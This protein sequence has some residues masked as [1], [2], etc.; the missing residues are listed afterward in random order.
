MMRL[1]SCFLLLGFAGELT[2]LGQ[3]SEGPPPKQT[4]ARLDQF[5]DPLP[6]GVLARMGSMR[7]DCEAPILA[8]AFAADGKSLSVLTEGKKIQLRFID[9]ATWKTT[10]R[11]TVP[12]GTIEY[13]LTPDNRL[14]VVRI[15]H[16]DEYCQEIRVLDANT[17]KLVWKPKDER[18]FGPMALSPDGKLLAGGSTKAVVVWD[19]ATGKER[20]VVTCLLNPV[21]ELVF[22]ADGKRLLASGKVGREL[23]VR[24]WE[25]PSG[26]LLHQVAPGG[27][28]YALSPGGNAL[29]FWWGEKLRLWDLDGGR[30]IAA[31]PVQ[32]VMSWNYRF[33][34]DGRGLVTGSTRDQLRVWDTATGQELR[35]LKGSRGDAVPLAFSPEGRLLLTCGQGTSGN[36]FRIW[37]V[38]RGRELDRF[39]G[40]HL[41]ISCLAFSPD[42]KRL[43]SGSDDHTARIWETTSGKELMVHNQHEA[44]ITAVAFS[45][46]GRTIAT[47]DQANVIHLWEAATG[48]LLQRL[49]SAHGNREGG[50]RSVSLLTFANDGKTLWVGNKTPFDGEDE[51]AEKGELALYDTASGK[52]IRITSS[53]IGFPLAVSPDLMLSVWSERKPVD[54]KYDRLV[55]RVLVRRLD[56][57]KELFQIA[58]VPERVSL[59]ERIDK[60]TFSPD[61]RL[62]AIQSRQLRP[63]FGG[64]EVW[65][66]WYCLVDLVTGQKIA[67]LN[68]TEFG[69]TMFTTDGRVVAGAAEAGP[70]GARR[71]ADYILRIVDVG[72]AATVSELPG[73]P[74]ADKACAV[75]PTGKLLAC[76]NSSNLTVV[77]WDL[78]Q[79]QFKLATPRDASA[80][81]LK[82]LWRDLLSDDAKE[83]FL[84]TAELVGSSVLS[85]PF[86]CERLQPAEGPSA[87]VIA[88]HIADLESESFKTREK[89]Q[90]ALEE[91]KELA[92]PALR[93]R[94]QEKP[95]LEMRQRAERLLEKLEGP[96]TA[97]HLRMVRAVAV[98]ERAATPDAR[99]HVAVLA[100]GAPGAWITREAEAALKRLGKVVP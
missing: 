19:T 23:A 87:E 64:K 81:D 72:S 48:L 49:P 3:R 62:M 11:L 9:L 79:Q 96:P 82:K 21:Q 34:P 100:A 80:P 40:H 75:W 5:G 63:N 42:G 1:A 30:E 31:L 26:T 36:G 60:V 44:P 20:A 14:L 84:A 90:A 94:L 91:L 38:A 76:A 88:R 43:V 59:R 18:Y 66:P 89:G 98:L 54:N 10:R 58:A 86:L 57:G 61:G 35:S 25:I 22:S 51:T 4:E 78:G 29:A 39:G 67:G 56:S 33:T 6:A 16:Q 46:D 7:R 2:A 12:E 13:A 83:A 52:R 50:Q 45:P 53:D 17:G 41:P 70:D 92:E 47:G 77:V 27:S 24:V 99:K 85:V 68:D 32:D 15:F 28:G 93:R 69:W 37:D 97:Q 74:A 8:A 65:D 55:S 73:Q 71:K 95:S